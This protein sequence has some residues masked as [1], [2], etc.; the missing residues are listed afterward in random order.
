MT[1][2]EKP[3]PPTNISLEPYLTAGQAVPLAKGRKVHSG[4]KTRK[5]ERSHEA[6]RVNVI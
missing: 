5:L 2:V 6:V 3:A 1:S 4:G